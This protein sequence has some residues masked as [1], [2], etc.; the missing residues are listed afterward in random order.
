MSQLR[1]RF[2]GSGGEGGKVGGLQGDGLAAEG[3]SLAGL[4]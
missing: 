2:L 1:G 4:L 3:G